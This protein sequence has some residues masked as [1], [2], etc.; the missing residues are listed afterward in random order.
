MAIDMSSRDNHEQR[1]IELEIK[2]SFK[3]SLDQVIVRHPNE[4]KLP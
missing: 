3:R 1:L 2:T 4:P